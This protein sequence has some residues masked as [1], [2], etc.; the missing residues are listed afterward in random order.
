MLWQC[1]SEPNMQQGFV[2]E[3]AIPKWQ[4]NML[5]L[6]F[7]LLEVFNTIFFLFLQ[8]LLSNQYYQIIHFSHVFRTTSS[9]PSV[10]L[11]LIYISGEWQEKWA[12][13][14]E[15]NGWWSVYLHKHRKTNF[16][17][18]SME[19]KPTLGCCSIRNYSEWQSMV[20]MILVATCYTNF[21]L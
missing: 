13:K 1:V 20:C 14:S 6:G 10:E 21:M 17:Y 4:H 5:Q 3:T 19:T 7:T 12:Q 8:S 9:S 16:I 15:R 2:P 11:I 18:E